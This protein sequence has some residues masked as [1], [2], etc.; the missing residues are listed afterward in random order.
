MPD[1]P[2]AKADLPLRNKFVWAAVALGGGFG[3]MLRFFWNK[4]FTEIN[5][6]FPLAQFTENIA[7]AFVLG[8]LLAI[9]IKRRGK[10]RYIRS[11]FGT[12]LIG[13]F[14]TFSGITT[15]MN[16]FL[17]LGIYSTDVTEFVLTDLMLFAGYPLISILCGLA[18]AWAGFLAGRKTR[19]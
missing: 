9:F 14:T 6:A 8:W 15:E 7:G 17:G 19:K 13:S 18:A 4:L 2:V 11:F 1:N 5:T 3:A 16:E 10:H 12:G